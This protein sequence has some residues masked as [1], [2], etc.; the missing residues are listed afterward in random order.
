MRRSVR[1][2]QTVHA[3]ITVMR[4]FFMVAA[5][6]IHFFAVNVFAHING[7]VAPLPDKSAAGTVILMIDSEIVFQVAGA[8]AHGMGI[9]TLDKGLIRIFC[10]ILMN[11][12][13]GS[14][15]PAV[16]IK[17]GIVIFSVMSRV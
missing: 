15:H 2:N 8:V 11:I 4:I 1:I 13:R 12:F 17:I 16:Q 5:V 14:I 6:S 10:K 9:F 3:E 7:M